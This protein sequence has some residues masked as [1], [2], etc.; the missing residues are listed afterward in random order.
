ML[1][2]LMVSV[3]TCAQRDRGRR[4]RADERREM[5]DYASRQSFNK[6]QRRVREVSYTTYNGFDSRRG[7]YRVNRVR[8]PS[9]NHIWVSGHWRYSRRLGC[10]VWVDG[11]WAVRRQYHRWVPAHYVTYDRRQVWVNAGWSRVY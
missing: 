11:R 5:R 2:L 9:R 7:Y 8:R 3:E 4:D 1:A 10:D 6:K